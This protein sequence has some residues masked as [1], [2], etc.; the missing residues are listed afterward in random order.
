M[1]ALEAFRYVAHF[2]VALQALD[3]KD[4]AN[5]FYENF[6]LMDVVLA[7]SVSRDL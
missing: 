6:W 1:Q 5:Q 2:S 7:G 3:E 4:Y